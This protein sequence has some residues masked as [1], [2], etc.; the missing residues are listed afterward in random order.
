MTGPARRRPAYLLPFFLP[1]WLLFNACGPADPA[2]HLDIEFEGDPIPAT[3]SRLVARSLRLLWTQATGQT[4]SSLPLSGRP[5]LRL[6]W[7]PAPGRVV[8]TAHASDGN[9]RQYA[10]R[11]RDNDRLRHLGTAAF[12][13]QV[14][15]DFLPAGSQP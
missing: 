10:V 9:T 5:S 1:L 6:I 8:L 7:R 2:V 12:L 13:R 14:R 11:R 3:Q 15:H 4:T